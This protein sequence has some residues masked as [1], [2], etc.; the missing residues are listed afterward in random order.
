MII[1]N[2]MKS[3]LVNNVIFR[4]VGLVDTS[5]LHFYRLGVFVP[6][7]FCCL[8]HFCGPVVRSLTRTTYQLAHRLFKSRIDYLP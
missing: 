4:M 1:C 7:L 8:C 5:L 3:A 6:K 2:A